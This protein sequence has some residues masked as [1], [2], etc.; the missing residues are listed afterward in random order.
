MENTLKFAESHEWVRDNGD[1]TITMGISSH[2]Q[3]LLG[4]VVFVD[5]PEVGD[6]TEAGE[7]FSLVESVKAASDIYAPVTGEIVEIN[8]ELEDSPE[9]INE[10]PYEGGWIAKIKVAD[11]EELSKL[12][13]G[14]KYLASI[15]ED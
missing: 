13:D 14:E 11:V 15:D 12:I 7:T 8:E 10:E 5:L 9:L 3:G 1:G 6:S 2:A 4:D